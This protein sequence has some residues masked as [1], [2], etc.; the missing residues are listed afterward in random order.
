MTYYP[1]HHDKLRAGVPLSK[2]YYKE[3]RNIEVK[4]VETHMLPKIAGD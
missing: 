3:P 4:E 1:E 2:R